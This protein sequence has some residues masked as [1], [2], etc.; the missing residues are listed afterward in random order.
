MLYASLSVMLNLCKQ[1]REPLLMV[2]LSGFFIITML[3][4]FDYFIFDR[5]L[6][7]NAITSLPDR[8]FASLRSI[9]TL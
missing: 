3:I 7:S 8:V 9:D 1:Y 6:T 5:E 4:L 2:D